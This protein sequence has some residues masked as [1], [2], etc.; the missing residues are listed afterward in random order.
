[1]AWNRTRY[2]LVKELVFYLGVATS[3][4]FQGLLIKSSSNPSGPQSFE[5]FTSVFLQACKYKCFFKSL[6]VT[7]VA[8][9]NALPLVLA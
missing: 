3:S 2:L 7:C 8:S 5:Q 4:L 6:E 1:M 9:F